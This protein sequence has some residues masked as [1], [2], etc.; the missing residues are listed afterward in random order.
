MT[1]ASDRRWYLRLAVLGMMAVA[2]AVAVAPG[3]VRAGTYT[4]STVAT[5]A[6]TTNAGNSGAIQQAIITLLTTDGQ[7][8]KD[9][10]TGVA[11]ALN[12]GASI[13]DVATAV[14]AV[15]QNNPSS[16]AANLLSALNGTSAAPKPSP[17]NFCTLMA[18]VAS[19]VGGT[20]Q[21][22]SLLASNDS[23]LA[24]DYAAD[25]P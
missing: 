8:T 3:A 7:S 22:Q 10:L 21:L 23:T 9:V 14:A 19:T 16:A 11:S 17:S 13:T 5:T 2:V 1:A 20:A 12:Q 18:T 4:P 24:S 15:F 6:I 25:C